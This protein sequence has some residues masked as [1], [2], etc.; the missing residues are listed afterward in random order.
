MYVC[1]G[2]RAHTPHAV[3]FCQGTSVLLFLLALLFV[4]KSNPCSRALE[5]ERTAVHLRKLCQGLNAVKS[6]RLNTALLIVAFFFWGAGG[7]DSCY[8]CAV[9]ERRELPER[10]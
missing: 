7:Q 9:K 8:G 2:I 5:G 3:H 1:G 6:P 10:I 4:S